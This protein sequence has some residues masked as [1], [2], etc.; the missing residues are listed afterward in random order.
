MEFLAAIHVPKKYSQP[1]GF[2]ENS[3]NCRKG[4]CIIKSAPEPMATL[5]PVYAKTAMGPP[6]NVTL[7]PNGCSD[8]TGDAF[9]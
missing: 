9:P 7:S 6:G 8:C 4:E 1:P 3:T 5:G 2:V